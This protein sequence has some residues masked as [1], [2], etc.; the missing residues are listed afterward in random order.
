LILFDDRSHAIHNFNTWKQQW[1]HGI[2][3]QD[4]E[5]LTSWLWP[6]L[7]KDTP[8]DYWSETEFLGFHMS[9]QGFIGMVRNA[10]LALVVLGLV[11]WFSLVYILSGICYPVINYFYFL[12]TK[13]DIEAI[14]RANIMIA[15][16]QLFIIGMFIYVV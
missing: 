9:G 15:M 3:P 16:V 12:T 2:K 6:K 5:M 11:P 13:D 4:T 1:L 14:W 7:W 10:P 8:N